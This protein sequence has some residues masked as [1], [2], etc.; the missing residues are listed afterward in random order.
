M[1]KEMKTLILITAVG[2][3]VALAI[4]FFGKRY[5]EKRFPKR[6]SRRP[7]FGTPEER[8]NHAEA[9]EIA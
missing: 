6:P 1:T 4:N 7:P 8:M 9:S 3:S 5:L 2:A